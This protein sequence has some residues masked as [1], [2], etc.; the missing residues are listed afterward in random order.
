MRDRQTPLLDVF[1]SFLIHRHDLSDATRAN[2]R[3]AVQGFVD[4]CT[5]QFQRP[6]EL[7]DIEGATVEAYLSFRT[8]SVSR[9][10]ARSAWVALR[11]LAEFLR[12]RRIHHDGGESTL[13]AVRMP[14]VKDEPRRALTDD[15]MW[16]LIARSTEG[17]SG[18]RDS[19]IVWTLL[20]CGLRREELASLRLCDVDFAERRLHVRA[21]TSKSVHARDV[22]VPLETLK[23]LDRYVH[24]LRI[25][26]SDEEARLFTDRSGTAVTGNAIRKLFERL[27]VRTGIAIF[28]PTCFGT[29]GLQT[30]TAQVQGRGST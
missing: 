7:A 5:A 8:A 12:E 20:G 19:A 6:A 3:F 21:G 15:E 10:S 28:R 18:P 4:W 26:P 29:R 2:Y 13:R 30:S 17:E 23:P 27:K 1:A 24:D 22:T 14:R 25:G 11:S 16:R 9:D